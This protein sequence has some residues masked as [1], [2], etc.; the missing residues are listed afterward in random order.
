MFLDILPKFSFDLHHIKTS[1]A[2]LNHLVPYLVFMSSGYL[3]T[4]KVYS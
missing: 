1:G 4:I 3:H 2:I